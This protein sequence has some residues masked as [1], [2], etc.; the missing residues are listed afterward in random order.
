MTSSNWTRENLAYL[1]G[2]LEGEGS[3]FL[4]GGHYPL[5]QVQ[6]TDEDIIRRVK[7]IVGFGP[8]SGP[9]TNRTQKKLNGESKKQSWLWSSG[10]QDQSYAL[11]VALYPWMGQRRQQKIREILTKWLE[12]W[13]PPRQRDEQGR[14]L[15]RW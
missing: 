1:A 3:F 5:I 7:E 6:M 4:R 12:E 13:R 15:K 9:Y 2:L 14:I 8:V 10:G 11:L